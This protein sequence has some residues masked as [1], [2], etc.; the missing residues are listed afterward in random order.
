MSFWSCNFLIYS[1]VGWIYEVVL[2]YHVFGI[3]INRGFLHG[4]YLPIYGFTGLILS[5]ILNIIIRKPIYIKRVPITPIIVF[6]IVFAV[7]SIVEYSASY[8]LEK[9]F[10]LVLW[11]Y[12]MYK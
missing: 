3:F 11:D 4:T 9:C 1:I 8:I 10:N 6:L 7:T 5:F 12:S 2:T